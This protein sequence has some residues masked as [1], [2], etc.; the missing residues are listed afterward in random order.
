MCTRSIKSNLPC[1]CK[2]PI[3]YRRFV[4]SLAVNAIDQASR[5]RIMTGNSETTFNPDGS[6]TRTQALKVLNQLFERPAQ[7]GITTSTFS[8]VPSPHWAIGEIEAAATE[9]IVKQ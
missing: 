3:I 2:S 6:L 5:W 9:R 7:K 8:D 1:L 4:P